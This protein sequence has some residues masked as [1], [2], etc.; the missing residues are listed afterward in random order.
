MK[1]S[2]LFFITILLQTAAQSQSAIDSFIRGIDISFTQQIEDLGGKYKLNGVEKDALDIFKENGVNYVRLRLWHTPKDANL[3]RI[4]QT[5]TD[6]SGYCGT[7]KT[8][9]YTK[10][11][12]AKGFKLLLDFH[13]SDWW[14]D[15]GKQNKPDAWLGIP[16]LALKDSIY[17]YTRYTIEAFRNEGVVPDMVQIGNEIT[18]GLLWPDGRVGGSYDTNWVR[19][20]DLVKEGIRGVKDAMADTTVKIMIHID[21]GGN[22]TTSKWFFDN[23]IARGVQFDIIGQSYYPWWHGTLAQLKANLNDLAMRY[24]KDLVIAETAY[25]WTTQYLNDGMSNIGI[26]ASKLPSGYAIS[27]QGQKSFLYMLRK[28][29]RETTNSKGIGFFYWEP[30]YISVPPIGSACE[31]LATFDFNG[32]A[33]SSI[34]AF[35]NVD[36]LKPIR[37]KLRFNTSTNP[38][39]LKPTGVVQVRGEIKGIGSN[40]LPSGELFTKDG[41]TQIV[42]LNIGGDYWECQFSMYPFDR[43]EYK[44]WTGHSSAKQTYWNIG[45]EGKILTYDNSNLNLRLLVAGLNDTILPVQFYSNSLS[46]SIPQYWTPFEQKQDS[47]GILFRVNLANL[48]SSGLFDPTTQVPVVVRGDSASTDGVLNWELNNIILVREPVGVANSSFW[49]EVMYLPKSLIAEGTTIEYKFFIEN[50]P[51][52][53]WES[54]IPNRTF[55]FTKNDT[56]LPWQFFNNKI[57]PTNVQESSQLVPAEIRLLPNYP[58]PFNPSTHLRYEINSREEVS[59]KIYNLLGQQ[60][61]TVVSEVMNAG[62]HS[63]EWSGDDDS[64]RQVGSGVYFVRLT[65]SGSSRIQKIVLL[66]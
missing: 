59:L 27:A 39:T 35:M 37:V 63:I 4:Y 40:L 31:H 23:L 29:I 30:A 17:S 46:T 57:S 34:S 44:L 10:K 20:T 3:M 8:I 43:L 56:T 47:V 48:L 7:A 61:R 58:N 6:T 2:L 38:D 51:F 49:S 52:G 64:G 1:K 9:A 25:P 55:T 14:A 18:S 62:E 32:N 16:F 54:N 19:F 65:S 50:S 66:R 13:Y 60:V 45:S 33:L 15:P 41:N 22:N 36:T 12:K 53:G 42:P 24:N 11:V 21:R 28:I 5:Q 26:D